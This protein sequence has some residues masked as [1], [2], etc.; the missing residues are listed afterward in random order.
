METNNKITYSSELMKDFK[1]ADKVSLQ[2]KFQAL[3]T[4][5]GYSLFFSIG[6]DNNFYLIEE[7]SGHVTGWETMDLSSQLATD[8]KDEKVVAKDFAVAQNVATG[9]IDMA[10]AITVNSRDYLYL[11]LNNKAENG[12]ITQKTVNWELEAYD[13]VNPTADKLEIKDLY[14]SETRWQEFIVVDIA[15]SIFI[16]RY[17]IDPTK[18][19][20]GKVWNEMV[21]GGNLTLNLST[22]LGMKSEESVDGIYTLG[23]LEDEL[24]LLYSPLY[25]APLP[26]GGGNDTPVI[27]T[28]LTMPT[29]ATSI[30]TVATEGNYTDLFVAGSKSLYYFP[31]DQQKDNDSGK[32]ILEHELFDGVTKLFASTN[33]TQVIIWGLNNANQVFYTTCDKNKLKDNSAWSC[34]VPL[35]SKVK[36]L[37]PYVNNVNHG[38][39]FFAASG[40]QITKALQSPQTTL[41]KKQHIMVKVPV[42]AK[43]KNFN[44][45]TTSIQYID[46]D[47]Q[48]INNKPLNISAST[49]VPVYINNLYFNL[50]TNP[51]P[52]STDKNG[53]ITIVEAVTSLTGTK[54]TVAENEGASVTINPMDKPFHKIATLDSPEKLK[55]AQITSYDGSTS[56]LVSQNT[57][58]DALVKVAHNSALLS[59]AYTRVS[60][61][62]SSAMA[63]SIA[64]PVSGGTL[65]ASLGSIVLDIG[66]LFSWLDSGIKHELELIEDE[67]TKIWKFVATI[68]GKVYHA[69][70]DTV[71]AVVSAV[72]WLFNTI[73]TDIDKLIKY[74]SFL[75][76]W[77]DITRTQKVIKNMSKLFMQQEIDGL[78]EVK[79]ALDEQMD[80]A[81]KIVDNWAGVG[82]WSGLG[83]AATS[84]TNKSSNPVGHQSSPGNLLSGHFRHN[85]LNISQISPLPSS[86]L[87]D[88]LFQTLFNALETEGTVLGDALNKLWDLAGDAAD[89][90]LEAILKEIIG[91]LA[92]TVIL[93][94]KVVMDALFDIL[95]AIS[96]D[97]MKILESEIYIPVVSDILDYFG[98]P[99]VTYLDLFCW[100]AAVPVTIVYKAEK[101]AAPFPDNATTKHLIDATSFSE[102][103]G[104]SSVDQDEVNGTAA[105]VLKSSIFTIPES[106]KNTIFGIGHLSAGFLTIIHAAVADQEAE[107]PPEDKNPYS[108][109]SAILGAITAVTSGAANII[110]PKDPVKNVAV[111][112][113]GRTSTT[114]TLL[115]KIIFSGPVQKKLK[116]SG[117]MK[118]LTVKDG[119]A[120]GAIVNS[121]LVLP[122][123]FVT[124]W[125]FYE[126]SNEKSDSNQ[127][128]AIIGE[129]GKV[130]SY[131][132]RVL[133]TFA[134]NDPGEISKNAIIQAMTISN[135]CT[136][137]LQ[138]GE[139]AA[140]A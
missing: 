107:I 115:C 84:K 54:F 57:A 108:I 42:G 9:K 132:S 133:Y 129:T 52:I 72:K 116:N 89:M 110:V 41:W 36:Q 111:S 135:V 27:I 125:H 77:D 12:T 87:P 31:T 69:V 26:G 17:Y 124:C 43:A 16:S 59:Q 62:S 98:V 68:A 97:V 102:I 83:M 3:Q 29:G 114:I 66:N 63:A 70:L 45:Y 30:A 47:R 86:S 93:S 48:P 23:K 61:R 131:I 134:V 105:T 34:P 55:T 126:L 10:L 46:P 74:L 35:A 25:N 14:I 122:S 2:K 49:R 96:E 138:F 58:Q 22:C 37:S 40:K 81:V 51:I 95:I 6:V 13:G 99:T 94:A 60:K 123:L 20:T 119:R 120:T 15:D 121:V 92:D 50:D 56:H 117:S 38:N 24:E 130:T 88:T 1:L 118:N 73:K 19:I 90:T 32:L 82:D 65:S 33:E 5:D 21:L 44:S 18:T 140:G 67:A 109:P 79:A 128:A 113:V 8:F 136:A 80:K 53:G 11:S 75:F 76:E 104:A 100:I 7:Q 137:G 85:V 64:L 101:K 4:T 127:K 106:V 28:R 139:A 39:M 103:T 78:K 91:I 112:W 71:E